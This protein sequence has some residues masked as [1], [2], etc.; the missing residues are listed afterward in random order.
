MHFPPLL[1]EPARVVA[2][3]QSSYSFTSSS[4]AYLHCTRPQ[5]NAGA[6]FF[7]PFLSIYWRREL[8][9]TN[10]QI[11]LL[12]ALRPWANALAGSLCM[13]LADIL[14]IH[15]PMLLATHALT[16]A[17]RGLMTLPFSFGIMLLLALIMECAVSP[18][19]IL[20]DATVVAGSNKVALLLHATGGVRFDTRP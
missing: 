17:S 13:P 14:Q 12:Q 15:Y 4:R 16:V 10:S 11:G 8:G 9:F 5:V 6:V 18:M 3:N 2:I 20:V 1:R 7:L 19:G